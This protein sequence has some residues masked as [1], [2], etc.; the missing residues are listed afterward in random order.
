MRAK[1][2]KLYGAVFGK[3]DGPE[4]DGVYAT[5]L[6]AS[7]NGCCPKNFG[8]FYGFGHA[9]NWPAIRLSGSPPPDP[10]QS[11]REPADRKRGR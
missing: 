7:A 4:A 11:H 5:L 10:A 2:D 9:S 3:D 8:F 6:K 1:N